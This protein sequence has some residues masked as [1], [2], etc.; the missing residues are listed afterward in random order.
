[1]RSYEAK[2]DTSSK[3][4]MKDLLSALLL[5]RLMV[6]AAGVVSRAIHSPRSVGHQRTLSYQVTMTKLRQ[7][8][9]AVDVQKT[10]LN[11][12][13]NSCHCWAQARGCQNT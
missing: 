6:L 12:V 8:R 2:A 10:L 1:L 11:T 5:R 4:A 3:D 7:Q 13:M 9:S